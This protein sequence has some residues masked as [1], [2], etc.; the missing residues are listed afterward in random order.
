MHI[1]TILEAATLGLAFF[2]AAA[3]AAPVPARMDDGTMAMVSR[4]AELA[5]S[6]ISLFSPPSLLY[7]STKRQRYTDIVNSSDCGLCCLA[8]G[9]RRNEPPRGARQEEEEGKEGYASGFPSHH[10]ST[11][12]TTTHTPCPLFLPIQLH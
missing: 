11:N 10:H 8:D 6:L 2:S 7:H 12:T 9:C 5:V 3:I 1:P 4:S